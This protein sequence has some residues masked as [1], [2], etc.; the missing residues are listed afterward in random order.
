MVARQPM[1]WSKG[2]VSG[3]QEGPERFRGTGMQ[4]VQIELNIKAG[5]YAPGAAHHCEEALDVLGGQPA[6]RSK[7]DG[8][9][10]HVDGDG[11]GEFGGHRM[12]ILYEKE[13]EAVCWTSTKIP[14]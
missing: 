9:G 2:S 12:Q 1:K 8:G 4:L 13:L 3:R 6:G 7:G 14:I 10:I 5:Q 11:D